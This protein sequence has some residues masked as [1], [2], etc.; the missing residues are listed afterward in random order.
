MAHLTVEGRR[1]YRGTEDH[2]NTTRE[3]RIE[4]EEENGDLTQ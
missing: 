2:R 1:S 4:L 3:T